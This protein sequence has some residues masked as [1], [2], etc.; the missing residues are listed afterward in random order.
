M[1]QARFSFQMEQHPLSV[2]ILTQG[3]HVQFCSL[4]LPQC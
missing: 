1:P 2:P 4:V 3:M